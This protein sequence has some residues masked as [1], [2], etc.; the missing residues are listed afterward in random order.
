MGQ[1]KQQFMEQREY[2]QHQDGSADTP[3]IE[4]GLTFS[5][6]SFLEFN[7]SDIKTVAMA[8]V[9]Q[10]ADGNKSWGDAVIFAKKLTELADLIKENT[11]DHALNELRL[12]D[13]E[14]RVVRGCE[15]NSQMTGVKYDYASTGHKKWIELNKQIKDE[16]TFL[17]SIK[18]S[19]TMV[20]EET[21]EVH[22]IKEPIK[23]GKMTLIIKVQ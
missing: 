4:T 16:E 14:K 21:G 15:I 20:D 11:A 18:G 2:E 8:V 22:T 13:K 1:S 19:K 17:R 10:C 9:D 6:Q 23:S 12:A 3:P 5:Q 7:K